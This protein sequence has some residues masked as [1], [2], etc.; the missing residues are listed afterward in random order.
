MKTFFKMYKQLAKSLAKPDIILLLLAVILLFNLLIF[1][2]FSGICTGKNIKPSAGMLDT[3][4]HYSAKDVETFLSSKTKAEK[5]C[6]ILVHLTADAVYPVIYSVFL[7]ILV[8]LL[9]TRLKLSN[10]VYT[11]ITAFPLFILISDYLEN[12]FIVILLAGSKARLDTLA[13]P[14]AYITPVVTTIK[15]SFVLINLL[16][17]VVLTVVRIYRSVKAR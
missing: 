9:G 1:P 6:S 10:A 5:K 4:I 13:R 14:L 2:Y 8:S 17:L 11:F 7:S 12:A 3:K 16:I 15:W